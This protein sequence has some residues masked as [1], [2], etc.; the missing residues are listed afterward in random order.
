MTDVEREYDYHS[1]WPAL[2]LTAGH[3]ALCAAVAG[4]TAA[5]RWPVDWPALYWA[6][7]AASAALLARAGLRIAA[8]LSFRH[9]VAFTKTCLLVPRSSW[10]PDEMAIAYRAITGLSL[11]TS[12]VSGTRRL[13]VMHAGGRYTIAAPLL[14]TQAAFAEVCEG[15]TARARADHA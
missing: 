13:Q 8:R 5:N 11:T 1:K 10:S 6:V 7:C 14:P 9:R 12:A 3:W 4:Y 2:L 15:L